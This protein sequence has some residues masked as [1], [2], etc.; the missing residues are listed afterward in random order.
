M[1]DVDR[2]ILEAWEKLGP[3]IMADPDELARRLARRRRP[4][5]TRPVRA[6]CLAL[7]ASDRRITPYDWIITPEHAMDLDHPEHAYEP[8]E[9]TVT[10]QPHGLRK[11]CRPV[12]TD[13]WGELVQDVARQLGCSNSTILRARWAGLFTERF[14]KGLGGKHG[15]SIPLIHSWKTLDPSGG[16]FFER[17]EQLWGSM[18]E[19]LPDMLPDDFE[20]TVVR[21]PLFRRHPAGMRAA[22]ADRLVRDPSNQYTD[23]YRLFGWLW[24][25][26][27]C[28]KTCRTIYCPLPP[29]TLF[30]Y[31][32][33][34]PAVNRGRVGRAP[35][36]FL[37]HDA[38]AVIPPP[39]AF[40]C[41][42]CHKVQGTTRTSS[43]CWNLVVTT[44][45]RGLLYGHEVPK[46]QWYE[47]RRKNARHRQLHRPAPRRQA[48]LRRL[49][50][51]WTERRIARD[52][53]MSLAQV[54]KNVRHLCQQ[55]NVADRVELAAKLACP[56][57]VEGASPHPQ[58]LNQ[59]Q[60]ARLRRRNV[61]KLLLQGLTN[62]QICALEGLALFEVKDEA[63]R[64][65]RKQG[66]APG[67]GRQALA[68]KLGIQLGGNYALNEELRTR[69]L[70]GQ[71]YRQ[72]ATEM[73]LTYPA[74]NKRG[75][76]ICHKEGMRGRKALLEKTRQS[77]P[78]ELAA[79]AK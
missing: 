64:I 54:H 20:Q 33:C 44:L 50:N 29:R 3:K 14:V 68:Q 15:P 51:G 21:T 49:L 1:N 18:W 53:L 25:C 46:P 41:G 2:L 52:L 57:L 24:L 4:I 75:T 37:R 60:N 12:R 58:P 77:T 7:R 79:I 22:G 40:A 19:W 36:K 5:M 55:E 31:L 63:H 39:P 32:G 65:Y 72:I 62:R 23:D 67:E 47:P 17:P 35:T 56:E 78:P 59:I 10:I 69:I 61:E 74:V 76:R 34:D 26:P 71:T 70:A 45:T 42:E 27:A 9:H 8:I 11:F 43:Q 13:S 66:L 73:G 30:D 28:K 6:W 48:V 38:E 16:R